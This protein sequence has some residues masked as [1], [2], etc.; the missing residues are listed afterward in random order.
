MQRYNITPKL[1]SRKSKTLETK[2]LLGILAS[3]SA[4]GRSQKPAIQRQFARAAG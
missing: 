4:R 3:A 1:E 2:E